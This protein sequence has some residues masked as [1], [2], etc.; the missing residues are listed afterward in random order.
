MR[1]VRITLGAFTKACSS[2][3]TAV[4]TFLWPATRSGWELRFSAGPRAFQLHR[5]PDDRGRR[6]ARGGERGLSYLDRLRVDQ[7]EGDNARLAA[8]VDPVV[9]RPALHDDVAGPQVHDAIVD[10][11]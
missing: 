7:N 2:C 11:H 5:R 8:V 3:S 9:D 4:G 1:K 10:L 6:L